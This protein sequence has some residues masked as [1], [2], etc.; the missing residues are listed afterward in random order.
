MLVYVDAIVI[1]SS[2]SSVLDRLLRQLSATFP[3]KD[4]GA[5]RY[6]L[7]I[8]VLPN[9]GGMT[10]I[11]KKYAPDLLQRTDMA[12]CKAVSTPMCTHE[13]LSRDTGHRLNEDEAF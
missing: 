9:S 6:F 2:S 13:K 5:L 10:L 8:E 7:G 12:N 1:V 11:Q 3:V 4:L